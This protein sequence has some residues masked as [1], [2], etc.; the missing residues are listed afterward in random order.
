MIF[1]KNGLQWSVRE[2]LALVVGSLI[3][4]LWFYL[5]VGLRPE[6]TYFYFFL[7]TL[8]FAHDY[9]RRF[10]MA[11]SAFTIYWLVYDSMRVVPNYE[12][13]PIHIIE[14]YQLEKQLFGVS[15][16]GGTLTWNEYFKVNRQSFLDVFSG[17]FY[18]G[19]VP[20]PLAFGFY[21]FLNNKK[22]FLKFSYAFLF[23][24]LV[25]FCIYY[26]YPAAPP[27][28]IEQYGFE[29]KHGTP[30]N[31]A[32]LLN[33]DQYFGISLFKGMYEKNAN[34]F[35]AMPSLHS[36]Y[37]V[38]CFLYGLKLRNKWLNTGFGLFIAGIWFAAVY[39]RHHYI[40]DVLAGGATA[41]TGYFLFEYLT[42]K[43]RLKS[44]FDNY[45]LKI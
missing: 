10:V 32:G 17:I 38:I 27:W 5:F 36:A 16:E 11:F 24:N 23:T 21:L 20:I 31:A 29:I 13:N 2:Y 41:L 12:V 22:L 4:F 40:I 33:F 25:G 42:E 43:T 8:Y 18:L 7:L 44:I 37:P 9:S 1:M 30:G 28:Y 19:W 15:T 45:A 39:T 26:A 14:P 34:V 3:Y 35:A 6:H